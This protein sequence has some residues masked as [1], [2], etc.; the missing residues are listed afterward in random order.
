MNIDARPAADRRLIRLS[1]DDNIAVAACPLA[2]GEVLPIA[3]RDLLALG[4]PRGREV[5]EVLAALR[6]EWIAAD[7]TGDRAALT[8]RARVLV[9]RILRDRS[10]SPERTSR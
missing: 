1:P 4:L 5:G 3:G 9:E 2:A 7:F 10:N 6:A 8:G